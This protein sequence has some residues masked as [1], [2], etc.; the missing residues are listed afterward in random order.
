MI[1]RGASIGIVIP[2]HNE[3]DY[4]GVTLESLRSQ[5]AGSSGSTEIVVVENGS[6]DETAAIVGAYVQDEDAGVSLVQQ[7]EASMVTS[8]AAGFA[9]LLAKERPPQYLVSADA[10]TLFPPSWLRSVLTR[11]ENGADV[12]SSAGYM[13]PELWARCPGLT[14]RYLDEV[15]TIFFDATT[16]DRL[17]ARGQSYLFTEEVFRDF[18]RPVSDAG[19]AMTSECYRRLGGF[20]RHRYV[21]GTEMAAVG[22][23]FMMNAD[24][25]GRRTEYMSEPAWSTSPRRLLQ[26]PSA[27]FNTTAYR[28][29]ITAFRSEDDDEYRSLDRLAESIDLRPLQEYCLK[30]YVLQRCVLR[31]EL[32]RLNQRYFG[33][34]LPDTEQAI[35]DWHREVSDPE[36]GQAFAFL[37]ELSAHVT[38]P[39]LERI[40][41][42]GLPA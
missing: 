40:R 32:L 2:A 24:F 37:D 20:Q 5:D 42:L 36:P 30:Y 14:R 17:G 9:R 29:A 31:P 3:A 4:I 39:L 26:E 13:S 34:H 41:S 10:D 25:A 7:D 35:Q 33:P 19:F 28:G 18:G 11:L 21:D 23:P 1:S 8:R 12:V 22:W 16:V 27:V 15:G 38:E 6:T